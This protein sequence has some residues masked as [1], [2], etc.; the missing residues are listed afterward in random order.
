MLLIFR[1]GRPVAMGTFLPALYHTKNGDL[2]VRYLYALGTH[3]DYRSQ[4][5]A[6]QIMTCGMELWDEPIVLS[7]GEPSLY[8]Y[9]EKQGFVRCFRSE[10]RSGRLSP[11]RNCRWNF[12]L[13]Q[14]EPG[15]YAAVRDQ[16]FSQAASAYLSWDADAVGFVF[17]V[18]E[19]EGGRNLFVIPEAAPDR[20]Q[21][22]MYV[23]EG[24]TLVIL[25]TTLNEELLDQLL[26]ELFAETGAHEVRYDVPGGMMLLPDR[27]AGFELPGDGY[28][29]LSLG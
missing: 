16:F 7:P 29:N 17:K 1:D 23:L 20:P 10:N 13:E 11:A 27:L 28:L 4:G 3:P 6:R 2:P 21:L 5:L 25:E 22:L 9:Y 26:P 14:A 18:N 12:R 24:H 8:R 19:R 15:Q